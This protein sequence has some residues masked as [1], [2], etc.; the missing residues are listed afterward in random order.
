MYRSIPLLAAIGLLA[1]PLSAQGAQGG[2]GGPSQLVTA[3]GNCQAIK[4]DAAR[5]ACFDR[6]AS[7]LVGAASR[8]EVAVIDREQVRQTRRTLFGFS[9]PR[10][11]SFLGMKDREAT[12][13]PRELVSTVTSFREGATPGRFRFTIADGNAVWETTESAQLSDPRPG[14]KVTIQRGALGSYFVQIGNQS[15]VR[16]RRVR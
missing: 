5:L 1:S 7:A 6:A 9:L 14:D 10:L 3:I 12:E 8:G 2:A 16:A 4:E 13:E 11:P 15:W